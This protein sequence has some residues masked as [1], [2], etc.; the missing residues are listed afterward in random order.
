MG[1]FLH[2]NLQRMQ[3]PYR[4]FMPV[5]LVVGV[6]NLGFQLFVSASVHHG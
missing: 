6:V 5:L 3:I 1:E 2:R 4:S